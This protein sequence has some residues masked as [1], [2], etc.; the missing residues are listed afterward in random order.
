MKINY[1]SFIFIFILSS[2]TL[3][4]SN[5]SSFDNQAHRG[6]RAL[7]PENTIPAML[8]AL[9]MGATTLEMDA[10]ITKDKQVVLSHDAHLSHYITT[11]PNGAYLTKDSAE[12]YRIYNMTYEELSQF[13]VGLKPHP[14][15]SEQQKIATTI[16]LLAEVLDACEKYVD[17]KQLKR[18]IYN[19]E[20]KS[21]PYTDSLYHPQP[22]EFVKLLM[23]VVADR[24][25]MKR[26]I[27]QSF[28]PRTLEVVHRNYPAVKTALLVEKIEKSQV[29]EWTRKFRHAK[30]AMFYAFPHHKSGVGGD[31]DFLSFKPDVYS[32][33]FN[34]VTF[35]M[36]IICHQLGIKIIPW[37]VNEQTTYQKLRKMGVDG[38]ISD[39]P[40][41]F[42]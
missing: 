35:D 9:D 18:P 3:N 26:V 5:N 39:D 23:Q 42:Q 7:M 25:L 2:C 40:R 13:D 36:I 21:K 14:Y 22:K 34:L 6:G 37:T 10:Q 27:I 33:N 28:D 29:Q 4:R 38:I 15:F 1:V 17:E 20:T 12:N 31:L 8:N 19:I 11:M 41:F 30:Q 32:P 24:N 16:P